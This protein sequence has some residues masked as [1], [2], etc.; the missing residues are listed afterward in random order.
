MNYTFRIRL[1]RGQNND[2][3]HQ[4]ST[5]SFTEVFVSRILLIEQTVPFIQ[6]SNYLLVSKYDWLLFPSISYIP[7]G[8]GN[9]TVEYQYQ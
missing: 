4:E 8:K 6:P 3:E 2:Q 1:K 7:S 9:M 5:F